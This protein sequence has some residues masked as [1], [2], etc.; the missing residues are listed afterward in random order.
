MKNSLLIILLF[1]IL[2]FGQIVVKSQENNKTEIVA[3]TDST[4]NL[5]NYK[6]AE[7]FLG[8]IGK[9]I[10]ALP[11]NPKY[12]TKYTGFGKIK[13]VAKEKTKTEYKKYNAGDLVPLESREFYNQNIGNK[14][15]IVK[16]I[17][18]FKNSFSDTQITAEEWQTQMKNASTVSN[19]NLYLSSNDLDIVVTN[20]GMFSLDGLLPEIFFE[21]LK[22]KYDN[23][24]FLYDNLYRYSLPTE[25]Q[26]KYRINYDANEIKEEDIYKTKE[27]VIEQLNSENAKFPDLYLV[28]ENIKSQKE[29]K[30]RLDKDVFDKIKNLVNYNAYSNFYSK[31][32]EEKNKKLEEKNKKLEEKKIKVY[33]L[34]GK[35]EGD[36]ILSGQVELGMD[37]LAVIY[38]LGYPDD[39]NETKSRYGVSEQFVYRSST[40][41]DRYYY[42][43][44]GKL[45]VIQK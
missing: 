4:N 20:N 25:E 37:T 45:T 26:L 42:F 14:Y 16:E 7:Q 19:I 3:K 21:Y 32:Q 31:S 24:T 9:K 30:L 18:F 40:F 2:S 10:F 6:T 8:L 1:P 11:I 33:E 5:K 41:G 12:D 36:K 17:K 29:L 35:K 22:K 23:K 15:F 39:R 13:Y 38:A 43:E 27:V 44:D 28:L 34:Y